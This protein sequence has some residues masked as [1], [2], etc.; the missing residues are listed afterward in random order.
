MVVQA[1]HDGANYK[2]LRR[3]SERKD[4]TAVYMGWQSWDITSSLGSMDDDDHRH[5]QLEQSVVLLAGPAGFAH[6]SMFK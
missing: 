2:A 6:T 3:S 4:M 5:L 1:P